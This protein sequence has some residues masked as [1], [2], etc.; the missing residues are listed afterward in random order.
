MDRSKPKDTGKMW[1]KGKK[2]QGGVFAILLL[3]SP[4]ARD[5]P[6][7]LYA[8]S[9]SDHLHLPSSADSNIIDLN[10]AAQ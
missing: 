3:S 2:T 6:L 9:P 5:P 4:L 7:P 8:H 1:K 10:S